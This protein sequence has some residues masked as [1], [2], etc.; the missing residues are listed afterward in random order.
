MTKKEGKISVWLKIRSRQKEMI[1]IMK[2]IISDQEKLLKVQID[3][4]VLRIEELD[5]HKLYYIFLE[6]ATHEEL[7][8]TS[9]MLSAVKKNLRWT[10]P[11]IT[12]INRPIKELSIEEL[13]QLIK[14]QRLLEKATKGGKDE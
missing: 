5:Q 13:E 9:Q 11:N 4:A 7:R 14:H 2:K 6:N 3:K 10:M 12:V 1:Q 8:S